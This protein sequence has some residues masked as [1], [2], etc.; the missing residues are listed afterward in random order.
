MRSALHRARR[1]LLFGVRSRGAGGAGIGRQA[2]RRILRRPEGRSARRALAHPKPGSRLRHDGTA[3]D[4][5]SQRAGDARS[6]AGRRR[7]DR[8][9]D[10]PRGAA[11]CRLWR[12]PVRLG[13]ERAEIDAG[14]G[15]EARG[16]RTVAALRRS[17]SRRSQG[18][19]RAERERC[20][21]RVHALERRRAVRAPDRAQA[22]VHHRRR[23]RGRA[24]DS[25]SSCPSRSSAPMRPGAMSTRSRSRGTRWFRTHCADAARPMPRRVRRSNACDL[26]PVSG[27]ARDW[28]YIHSR[29]PPIRGVAA[30]SDTFA[31][32]ER[33]RMPRSLSTDA[34]D[35]RKTAEPN[36]PRCAAG[37]AVRRVGAMNGIR[38]CRP[39]RRG[40]R[41]VTGRRAASRP[42]DCDRTTVTAIADDAT[43]F[44]LPRVDVIELVAEEF[45]ARIGR[46]T[47]LGQAESPDADPARLRPAPQSTY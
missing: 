34:D 14:D 13:V 24:A 44:Q 5:P 23:A 45:A 38:R 32:R 7:D 30:F 10:P 18:R 36:H 43:T 16:H 3:R 8:R 9:P 41:G 42:P 35:A 40:Y 2:A 1:H 47:H 19:G 31:V 15:V 21:R 22:D 11:A 20:D 17:T 33:R 29:T 37:A 28:S 25:S 26:Q 46:V 4:R 6:A 12:R 27:R 39:A